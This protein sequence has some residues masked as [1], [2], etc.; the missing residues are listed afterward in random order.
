MITCA[1]TIA[2][3]LIALPIASYLYCSVL[4]KV[5]KGSLFFINRSSQAKK[6]DQSTLLDQIIEFLE[7]HANAKQLR[8]LSIK[9]NTR[10]YYHEKRQ[11]L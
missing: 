11:F 5:I 7:L 9:L 10:N 4:S 3:P 2:A 1:L 8:K 6:P